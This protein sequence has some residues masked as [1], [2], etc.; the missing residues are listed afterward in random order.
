MAVQPQHN[1]L[2]QSKHPLPDS[3]RKPKQAAQTECDEYPQAIEWLA[4][5]RT[6]L[7]EYNRRIELSGVF[8][9]GLR[10]Y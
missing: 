10:R 4:E 6:A 8:S 5:N 1:L 7:E 2:H 9:E 3:S